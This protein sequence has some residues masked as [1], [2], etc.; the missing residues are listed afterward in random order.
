MKKYLTVLFAVISA[1]SLIAQE[2][3]THSEEH[4]KYILDLIRNEALTEQRGY[5]WLEELCNDIGP[6]LSGSENYSKSVDWAVNKFKA[7][8]VDT[9]WTQHVMVPY[10]VRGSVEYA[11]ISESNEYKGKELSIAALGGSIGTPGNGLT[12]EVI[13]VNNFEELRAL[14]EQVKG[15]IVFFNKKF[16]VSLLHSFSGYG[17][18]VGLRVQGAIEAAKQGAAAVLLRSITS[19][20]DDVPHT[21]VMRYA[22]S[23]KLIPAAALGVKSSDLLSEALSSDPRLKVT[24]KMDCKTYPDTDSWSVIADIKGTE[25]P[26]EIIV[27]GGHWDSWDKG[28]GAHDD[29]APCIQ[30]MEVLDLFKRLGIKPK[31]TIRCVLF[32]NEENGLRGGVA[33]GRYADNHPTEKHI[34]AIES[35]RGVYTPRGFNVDTDEQTIEQMQ[36]WLPILNGTHINYIKKGGSGAD[37]GQIK[38]AK[39]LAGYV[40]DAVRYFDVHHSGNDTFDSVHP[41]EMQWGTTAIAMF[42]YFMSEEL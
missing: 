33:Y 41:L 9:V 18:N 10:W 29:G 38:S 34:G 2:F 15:K 17:A 3:K 11:E 42:A 24:I 32:A 12:A 36:A 25:K 22:D 20:N 16:D 13:E 23:L 26:N 7:M 5:L 19:K 8:G 28:C 21:G 39:V 40:P 30:T 37:V 6:R 4:Y 35:D 14:G 31:R 1:A 27:V